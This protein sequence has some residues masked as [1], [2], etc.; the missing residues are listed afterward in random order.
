MSCKSHLCSVSGTLSAV[1]DELW[2]VWKPRKRA[3]CTCSVDA[4][5]DHVPLVL[6]SAL[7]RKGAAVR[8]PNKI[9]LVSRAL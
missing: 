7:L 2:T 6:F 1:F 4:C 8:A 3:A 5:S 9:L